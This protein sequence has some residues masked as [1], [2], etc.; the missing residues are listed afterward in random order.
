MNI[1]LDSIV[2][3]GH[4]RE[5]LPGATVPGRLLLVDDVCTTGATLFDAT[6]ALR[7]AGAA[8]VWC[9]TFARVW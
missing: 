6:D 1:V 5:A 3:I 2:I 7:R 4:C 8:H 9:L